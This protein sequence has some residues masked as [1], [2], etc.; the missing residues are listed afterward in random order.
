MGNLKLKWSHMPFVF[1]CILLFGCKGEV[2]H[3]T[4][5]GLY[6]F[7]GWGNTRIPRT[8][9]GEADP[10]DISG[11]V[12]HAIS[13]DRPSADCIG[14]A[15]EEQH[16]F[17]Q[18]GIISGSLPPGLHFGRE[19]R[20]SING[21]PTERGHWIVTLKLY[22]IHCGDLTFSAGFTQQLRFHIT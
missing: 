4:E 19:R 12:G 5:P 9:E 20:F 13:V 16:W 1:M 8:L 10:V 6:H 18:A 11:E 7:T 21:V 2:R 22:D 15:G 17:A 3:V 14:K